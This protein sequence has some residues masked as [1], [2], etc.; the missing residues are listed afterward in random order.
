LEI[1]LAEL[2][3]QYAVEQ[4]R[5]LEIDPD[6][7]FPAPRTLTDFDYLW[8]LETTNAMGVEYIP[9]TLGREPNLSYIVD[10]ALG[11]YTVYCFITDRIDGRKYTITTSLR[12][13][14][15]TATGMMVLSNVEGYA[16]VSFINSFGEVSTDVYTTRNGQ[17]AGRNPL[18][19]TS[20]GPNR[21]TWI[22]LASHEHTIFILCDDETGGVVCEPLLFTHIFDLGEMFV[23][24]P[25]KIRPLQI[26]TPSFGMYDLINNNGH[27]HYRQLDTQYPLFQLPATAS[28]EY[29][30]FPYLAYNSISLIHGYCNRNQRFVKFSTGSP[31][32]VSFYDSGDFTELPFNPGVST[33]KEMIFAINLDEDNVGGN[34]PYRCILQD[35][36]GKKDLYG[37]MLTASSFTPVFVSD[38]SIHPQLDQADKFTF[39]ANG[40]ILLAAESRRI[41][42]FGAEANQLFGTTELDLPAGE[43]IDHIAIDQRSTYLYVGVS[44]GSRTAGSGSVY[45]YSINNAT[46]DLT[47]I[48]SYRN[49]SGQIVDFEWKQMSF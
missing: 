10:Q 24:R 30:L 36:E 20:S 3:E 11:N 6:W 40:T 33:G 44:D 2:P 5:L 35:T 26:F 21:N 9:D 22:D 45:I 27:F 41:H 14:N 48:E 28:F 17:P 39:T 1:T 32:V 15:I 19:I 43:T 8:V 7:A 13:T 46:G 42:A 37:A 34:H 23:I 49:I 31:P 38:L 16:Q 4:L 25:E 29:D 18:S 47:L 12:V